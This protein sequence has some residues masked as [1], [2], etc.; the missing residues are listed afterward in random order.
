MAIYI[1]GM[2]GIGDNLH[3]R[4][5]VKYYSKLHDTV[6]LETSWPQLYWD[7]PNVKFLAK[8]TDLRT[9][10]KNQDRDASMYIEAT[11]VPNN[12]DQRKVAYGPGMIRASSGSVVLA[13]L[14]TS[15]VPAHEADYSFQ[16]KPE[17]I[18]Q[19]EKL[20]TANGKPILVYRPLIVRTEWQAACVARNPD[21]KS[22]K[23]LFDLIRDKYHVVSIADLVDDVEWIV[24]D[25][26]EADQE[27]HKGE[28]SIELLAGLFGMASLVY[29][30]PGFSTV[31]ARSM[32]LP[33]ITV[34]GGYENS[35]SFGVG[36]GPFLGIDTIKPCDCFQHEHNCVKEI[37]FEKASEAILNFI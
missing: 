23:G 26:I 22:Y 11:E 25:P 7:L 14:K 12:I 28:L 16:P 20:I 34:F 29:C 32:E 30:S 27:F 36:K 21:F 15:R 3:Q 8:G 13:M 17:W 1:R 24:S 37:D 19:A 33:V 2:H 4:A 31:L 35:H 5:V 9:Q 6:Y 10:R 18:E